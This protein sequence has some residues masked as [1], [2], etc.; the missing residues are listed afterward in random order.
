MDIS[1]E[2]IMKYGIG[3]KI[4]LEKRLNIEGIHNV[5]YITNKL[6]SYKDEIR[7]DFHG[8]KLPP[9]KKLHVQQIG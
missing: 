9:E 6:K 5:K 2:N 7:I 8:N 3:L 4:F 1:R